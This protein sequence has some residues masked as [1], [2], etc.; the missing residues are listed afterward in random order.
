MTQLMSTKMT[1]NYDKDRYK[2]STVKILPG[3][4]GRKLPDILRYRAAF[5]RGH[6]EN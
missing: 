5:R 4:N 2:N 6:F 3:T 1:I